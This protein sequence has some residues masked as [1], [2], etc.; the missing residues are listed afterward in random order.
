VVVRRWSLV[1]FC[2]SVLIRF[3]VKALIEWLWVKR[4]FESRLITSHP[5][6]RTTND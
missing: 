4:R 1:G 6:H 2:R 3:L 5:T